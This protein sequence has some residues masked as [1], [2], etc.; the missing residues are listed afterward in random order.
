[1]VIVLRNENAQREWRGED[2]TRLPQ[3]FTEALAYVEGG[4]DKWRRNVP[5][6]T[7]TSVGYRGSDMAVRYHATDIVTFFCNGDILLQFNG[8]HTNTT[9]LRM[10]GCLPRGWK[11]YQK[12]WQTYLVAPDGREMAIG[13]DV[14]ITA[15]Q[16]R[17]GE[18][19]PMREEQGA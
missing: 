10:N 2:M 4:R 7:G 15:E 12:D 18:M 17:R 16:L 19:L 6:L 1:M 13:D 8:W 14:L 3:N 11:V 5:G 9:R